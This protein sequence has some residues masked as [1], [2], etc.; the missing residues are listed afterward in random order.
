M[1]EDLKQIDGSSRT[2]A[3][4]ET[5]TRRGPKAFKNLVK[6]LNESG[7][8]PAAEILE[9]AFN[10]SHH[11]SLPNRTTQSITSATNYSANGKVWNRPTY[12]TNSLLNTDSVSLMPTGFQK[13]D[14]SWISP[15]ASQ[16]CVNKEISS[17]SSMDLNCGSQQSDRLHNTQTSSANT[18]LLPSPTL[19]RESNQQMLQNTPLKISVKKASKYLGLSKS[20]GIKRCYPMFSKPRGYALIINNESFVNDI[21]KYRSGSTIDANNLDILFEQLGFKVIVQNNRTYQEMRED[22]NTFAQRKEHALSNMAIVVLLSHGEDGLVFGTDGRKVPNEWILGQFNNDNCP[23]L[24]GKPKLFIFQACRGEDP[25]YGTSLL[26][27]RLDQI[28]GASGTQFDSCEVLSPI[29]PSLSDKARIP[30]V[31]DMLIAYATVPGYVANRD[32]MRGTW[33]IESICNV[34]MQHAIDTDIKEMMDEVSHEMRN[35]E[36]EFGTKQSCSYEVRHF[37]KKLFFNPGIYFDENPFPRSSVELSQKNKS[38][39][40]DDL[41]K[42]Q[43]KGTVETKACFDMQYQNNLQTRYAEKSGGMANPDLYQTQGTK[44]FNQVNDMFV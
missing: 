40:S 33:F 41:I 42:M 10:G 39:L 37:Y 17:S 34:F 22:I 11:I 30:T 18:V 43:L 12:E 25:D 1:I 14:P 7:N 6:A 8:T 29:F 24:K 15:T 32:S 27:P 21:Y 44:G 31:E 35:Y 4:Y 5:V 3:L 20:L 9:P 13:Y 19:P 23:N 38:D 28:D 36:S 16:E 2:R 26:I